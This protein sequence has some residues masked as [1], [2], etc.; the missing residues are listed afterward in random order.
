MAR[1]I[2]PG[3]GENVWPPSL[4]SANRTFRH[5]EVA[6]DALWEL[7]AEVIKIGVEPNGHNINLKCNQGTDGLVTTDRVVG[8][9]AAAAV[10]T[11]WVPYSYGD[12]N[13]RVGIAVDGGTPSEVKYS[14]L[15]GT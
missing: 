12:A 5:A 14:V 6:P 8:P 11:V 2:G 4:D 1:S 10:W 3:Q 15:A 7:G 9:I 13:Q